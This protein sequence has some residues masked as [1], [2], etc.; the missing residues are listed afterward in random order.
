MT[1][2]TVMEPLTVL[3]LSGSLRRQSHNTALL[4][5]A[6]RLAPEMFF[7]HVSSV[8]E[9]P[10]FDE[11][12][13]YP[14]P[15]PVARLRTRVAAADAILLA[16]PEYNAGVPGGLK[17]ALD[18]LSRPAD[19]QGPLLRGKPVAILG[20][21]AGPFGTV[22]AQTALRTIL[23]KLDA[24]VLRQPEFLLPFAHQHL[25]DGRLEDDSLPADLLRQVLAA[26]RGLTRAAIEAA[27]AA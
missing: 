25:V 22:K 17:N 20:A 27:A 6:E 4:R 1:Q 13:E 24:D 3:T 8:G 2:E 21:S 10:F 16:T 5:E 14:T 18:W 19:E 9:L 7:D 23:H 26:L 12:V 15:G 11:D